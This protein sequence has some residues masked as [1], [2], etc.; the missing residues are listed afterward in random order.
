MKD[1]TMFNK[2]AKNSVWRLARGVG[3]LH[4]RVK[5][6]GAENLPAKGGVLLLPNHVSY[7]DALVLSLASPRPIRFLSEDVL[8]KKPVLGWILRRFG[9]IPVSSRRAKE[10]IVR[11]S[12]ALTAGEVVCLFLEGKLTRDGEL[13]E[14]QAGFQLIARRANC[15]I[16]VARMD[17]LWD[18]VFSYFGGRLFT[19]LPHRL[20]RRISVSF[21]VPL[22]VDDVS[23]ELVAKELRLL[24]E[25]SPSRHATKRRLVNISFL[26]LVA[27]TVSVFFH[28]AKNPDSAGLLYAVGGLLT[29]ALVMALNKIRHR[30]LQRL[31]IR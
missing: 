18:S 28:T 8:F 2:L 31:K 17:G 19:K 12:A 4:Y 23:P 11:A 3:G 25:Q 6:R 20:I 16:V 21:S 13:G 24:R 26:L 5:V 1:K 7:V 9:G 14:L 10:A 27:L 29:L 15:Q 30:I 22:T